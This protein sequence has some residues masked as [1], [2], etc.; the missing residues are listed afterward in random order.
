MNFIKSTF[1]CASLWSAAL[2]CSLANGATL[3]TAV[4][5]NDS[6]VYFGSNN[7]GSNG[8]TT[9][10][11][12]SGGQ[13]YN[14]ADFL[15]HHTF[16]VV[17][18]DVSGL[19]TVANGGPQKYLTLDWI[20]PGQAEVA[21]SVAGADIET[22]YTF[23]PFFPQDGNHD[24]RLQWY[25]DNIKG[26]DAAY[27]GY[28]GGATHVGVI[29]PRSPSPFSLDVTA[30]V[31]AWID[32]STPNYGFGLWAVSSA[33]GQGGTLDFA[34]SEYAGGGGFAGPRLTSQ[35]I[36]EPATAALS[37]LTLAVAATRSAFRKTNRV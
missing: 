26:D 23:G 12:V 31:D 13:F 29:N 20:Q 1:T 5:D 37:L 15:G 4:Y 25:F 6:Y 18:F 14:G 17:K 19:Q 34:S 21:V 11:D 7:A 32:G 16:A 22:G 30:V 10:A 35:P 2:A 36:P 33:G 3:A 28:A 8:I 9:T 27:G 24:A